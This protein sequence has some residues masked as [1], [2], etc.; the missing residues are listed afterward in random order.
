MFDELTTSRTEVND[1]AKKYVAIEISIIKEVASR[2]NQPKEEEQ[3]ALEE[4]HVEPTS[5]A[6]LRAKRTINPTNR[7]I[8]AC[9]AFL[10]GEGDPSCFQEA[11]ESN[12]RQR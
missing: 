11:I 7:Y 4:V 6:Q 9:Y 3:Q 10:A 12:E 5:L 2:R 8:E 1:G